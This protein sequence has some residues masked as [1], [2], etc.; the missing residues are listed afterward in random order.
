VLGQGGFG[1]V[2]LAF[3]PDVG[4]PVAIKMM[5]ADGDPDLRRFQLEIRTTA[6]LRHKNIVTIYASGEEDGN[7]YLVMEFL[8]GRTLKQIIQERHPLSVLDKVHIMDAGRRGPRLRQFQWGRAPR[9]E[10]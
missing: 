6:S 8:E 2:Y 10:A 4:Q 9:C 3:D 7:P 5:L 1:K